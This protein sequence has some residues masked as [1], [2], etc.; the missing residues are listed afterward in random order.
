MITNDRSS[1]VRSLL[2]RVRGWAI[3]RPDVVAV[4]LA[5]SWA[6]GEAR[7]DSDVDLVV[8]TTAKDDYLRDESWIEEFC[9]LRI[10]RTQNWGSLYTERRFALASGLEV[11][12]GVALPAWAATDPPD[13]G[14]CEVVR[15]GKL[16]AVY[17]PEGLLERFIRV[18]GEP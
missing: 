8:L 3:D 18:C 7:M 2:S 5:G 1:E 16:R 6:R 15:D 11:E 17:D 4:A 12:F 14:T 13:P 9:G 10:L